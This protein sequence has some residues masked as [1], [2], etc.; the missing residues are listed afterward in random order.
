MG[1][2]TAGDLKR[3]PFYFFM[4]KFIFIRCMRKKKLSCVQEAS[5]SRA[6]DAAEVIYWTFLEKLHEWPIEKPR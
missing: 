3:R 5:S 2:A 1:S 6:F 4:Y